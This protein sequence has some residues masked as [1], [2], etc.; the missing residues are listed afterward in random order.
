MTNPGWT[1]GWNRIA[2][3]GLM[4]LAIV[5]SAG[6]GVRA[7]D[8]DE[9]EAIDTKI[10]RGFLSGLGLRRDGGGI[11]YRERSPLV[12]P[13]TRDTSA[14]ALPAPQSGSIVEK[15]AAWPVD[16]DVK[17][18]KEIKAARK[19]PRKDLESEESRPELPSQLGP[20]H[21][22][23]PAHQR[24]TG[25]PVKDTTAPSTWQELGSKS[26]FTIGGLMWKKQETAT[27]TREP[28][29]SSLTEP[30][31]GYRTPSPAHPYGLGVAKPE[32]INPMDTDQMRGR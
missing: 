31:P 4:G 26:F 23:A 3:A 7:A 13:P 17:R 28:Q 6:T 2:A 12:V 11:D 16:P 22:S 19:K 15:T 29:R 8:D 14:P 18:A 24:P 20:R 27:F 9:D 10:I 30:P 21:A 5:A 1:Y 32:A 25:E